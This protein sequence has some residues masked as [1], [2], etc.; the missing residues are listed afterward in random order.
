MTLSA[1]LT[2]LLAFGFGGFVLTM[3][4]MVALLSIFRQRREGRTVKFSSATHPAHL[5]EEPAIAMVSEETRP[6]KTVA[7]TRPVAR[8]SYVEEP[9]NFRLPVREGTPDQ[10]VIQIDAPDGP[11]RAQA[12]VQRIIDY[13]KMD[14]PENESQANAS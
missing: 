12:N 3:I 1:I 9:E 4:S 7:K 2:L 8:I 10:V 6:T 11:S 13:L 5:I 14:E